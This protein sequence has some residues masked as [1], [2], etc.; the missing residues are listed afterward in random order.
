MSDTVVF[1]EA[2][3]RRER[4]QRALL[5]L[6]VERSPRPHTASVGW[7]NGA[8]TGGVTSDRTRPVSATPD[9]VA[10]VGNAVTRPGAG[11]LRCGLDRRVHSDT[12][13]CGMRAR[14]IH[15][16]LAGVGPGELSRRIDDLAGPDSLLLS[17]SSACISTRWL[18]RSGCEAAI[19][20]QG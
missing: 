8:N 9:K 10:V 20:V 18:T 17:Q 11:R 7:W 16:C 13:P 14:A 2:R 12:R 5:A 3:M 1:D 4:K 6:A 19:I 15:Q